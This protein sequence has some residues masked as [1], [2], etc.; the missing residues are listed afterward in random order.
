MN[1]M[2][3]DDLLN[4]LREG[5]VEV[6][7]VKKNGDK[8]L[9]VSTLNFDMIP[10]DFWPKGMKD[11]EDYKREI[12]DTIAVFDMEKRAWRSFDIFSVEKINGEETNVVH[13]QR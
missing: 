5:K 6:E 4:L 9:L 3:Y 10:E 1:T 7:F 2:M 13:F 11:K 8:R 12:K